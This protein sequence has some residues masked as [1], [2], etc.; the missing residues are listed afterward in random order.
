MIR[1]RIVS[2]VESE[3]IPKGFE[4]NLHSSLSTLHSSTNP[5][6]HMWTEQLPNLNL[7]VIIL[8]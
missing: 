7:K 5:H 6:L 8:D 3:Q 2:I 1:R 4:P